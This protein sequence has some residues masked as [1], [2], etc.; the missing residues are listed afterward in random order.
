M[1]DFGNNLQEQSAVEVPEKEQAAQEMVPNPTK[2][3]SDSINITLSKFI[4]YGCYVFAVIF[5]IAAIVAY[6]KDLDCYDTPFDFRE[7]RYVGGDAYNYIISAARSTT[8]M[9]KCL[10]MTV[11]GFSFAIIGRLT[12]LINKKG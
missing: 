3:K 1:A 8:V 5:L 6:N 11:T 10:V 9:V 4:E 2:E 12:A 7:H